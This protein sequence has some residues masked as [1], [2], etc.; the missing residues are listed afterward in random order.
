MNVAVAAFTALSLS[1]APPALVELPER[2]SVT[3]GA[4]VSGEPWWA[5]TAVAAIVDEALSA[6]LDGR[7]AAGRLLAA[8]A[9]ADQTKAPLYPWLSGNI[10]A[11][12]QPF[13]GLTFNFGDI[14]IPMGMNTMMM[15]PEPDPDVLVTGSATF[16]LLYKVDSLWRQAV[17]HKAAELNVSA[18]AAERDA[19]GLAL[20]TR[21]A[22]AYYDVAAANEQV[23][24]ITA[25]IAVNES[26][27]ELVELRFNRGEA[28]G[29]DVLQQRQQVA[30]AKAR[31]PD[32]RVFGR[33]AAQR[34][35]VLLGRA[36]TTPLD[37]P[38]DALPTTVSLPPIGAPA[39]LADNR[40][41]L[42]AAQAR[43]DASVERVTAAERAHLPTLT[44][45]G[46]AGMQARYSDEWSDQATWSLGLAMSLPIFRGGM[47]VAAVRAA[48]AEET[49][50]KYSYGQLLLQAVAEVEGLL[51]R[52]SEQ[53]E[54]LEA[55]EAARDA[56]ALAL[57]E[58]RARY[59]NG[60]VSYLTVLTALNGLHGSELGIVAARRGRLNT[61][62]AL[63]GAIGGAWT[64]GLLT[65]AK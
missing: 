22:G 36:P 49:V 64:K 46:S 7:A 59:V 52:F 44:L 43:W 38:P 56:A 30:S 28:S 50:A 1:A 51:V 3:T 23:A 13:G 6:N 42:R 31:L 18:T 40:P 10:S 2:Y 29:L 60:L 21:V 11:R 54:A 4:D 15:A 12:L 45:S 58:S 25:Q 16:D 47:D 35:S 19:F 32:A 24:K 57:D 41:N 26:F 61:Q 8:D 20:S 14:D 62:V 39:D 53:T 55:L 9:I 5:N 37:S 63:Q 27:L 33:V 48:S 65:G 34:L 17:L